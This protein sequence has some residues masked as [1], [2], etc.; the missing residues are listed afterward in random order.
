VDRGHT[1]LAACDVDDLVDVVPVVLEGQRL[2]RVD[3]SGGVLGVS[4]VARVLAAEAYF[5]APASVTVV[6]DM[7]VVVGPRT[8]NVSS[9]DP[10]G[11]WLL[12]AAIL[13]SAP[14]T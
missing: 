8:V 10:R 14:R 4:G 12:V 9:R 5:A 2:S 13:T 7:A 6:R 3:R 1:G 11:D